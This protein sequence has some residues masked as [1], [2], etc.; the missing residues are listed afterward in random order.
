MS[1]KLGVQYGI[2]RGHRPGFSVDKPFLLMHIFKTAGSSLRLQIEKTIDARSRQGVYAA[3]TPRDRLKRYTAEANTVPGSC[4]YYGHFF[5]GLHNQLNCEPNYGALL[6]DP[7]A[8]AVSHFQHFHRNDQP[9]TTSLSDLLDAREVQLDNLQTRMISGHRA[10][11]YGDVTEAHLDD[12]LANLQSFTYVGDVEQMDASVARLGALLGTH[13]EA[14][15]PVNVHHQ[16]AAVTDAERGR[17]RELNWA[18]KVLY[19]AAQDV[20]AQG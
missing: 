6:R 20:I 5:Y 2:G 4:F 17:L 14:A 15:P 10:V 16:R 11:G 18:D 8:R 3:T 19:E 13:L 1:R 9:N 7:V 12:A